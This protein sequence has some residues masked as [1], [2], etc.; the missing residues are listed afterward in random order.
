MRSCIED[1]GVR[2]MLPR[3]LGGKVLPREDEEG[4]LL[5]AHVI[6]SALEAAPNLITPAGVASSTNLI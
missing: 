6:G 4:S 5:L 2:L 3:C 1:V